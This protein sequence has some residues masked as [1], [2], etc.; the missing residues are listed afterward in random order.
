MKKRNLL[1]CMLG[2]LAVVMLR[3]SLA[4]CGGGDSSSEEGYTPPP[5]PEDPNS[6]LYGKWF[7][8]SSSTY[9]TLIFGPNQQGSIEMNSTKPYAHNCDFHYQYNAFTNRI[10]FN[11]ADGSSVGYFCFDINGDEEEFKGGDKMII[12]N[13]YDMKFK[14]SRIESGGGS[15]GSGTG[16]ETVVS[17]RTLV[18]KTNNLTDTH[19]S[20]Y[21]TYYKK[22]YSSGEVELYS[23]AACTSK[24]GKADSNGLSTWGGISV[25]SYDYLVRDVASHSS[26]YYF[27]N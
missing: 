8:S 27:F 2:A 16:T 7:G 9:M 15:G 10:Y 26:T 6:I 22:T 20:S 1:C 21:S 18:I 24:I 11:F 23:N 3:V 13:D 5:T 17:T 4:A 14:M 19:T 12:I 25:R